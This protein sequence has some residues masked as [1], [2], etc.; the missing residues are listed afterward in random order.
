MLKLYNY[1]EGWKLSPS[2]ITKRGNMV[3][4]SNLACA[5]FQVSYEEAKDA[6]KH[7]KTGGRMVITI[8]ASH[9]PLI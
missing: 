5:E 2:K 9:H 6:I 7:Y 4:N 3:L 1:Y 8:P